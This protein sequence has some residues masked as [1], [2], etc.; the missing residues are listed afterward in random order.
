[1]STLHSDDTE[2]L[3]DPEDSWRRARITEEAIAE[4]RKH[5]GVKQPITSWTR[6]ANAEAL[7]HFAL[8]VGDDNP[9]WWDR[10]YASHSKVGRM[11]APPS[12]LYTVSTDVP[13]PRADFGTSDV[14]WLP[15]VMGLWAGDRWRWYDRIWVDET[16]T[17]T[18]ELHS[19]AEK[20][21]SFGGRGVVQ[22]ELLTFEGEGPR[23]LAEV[24]R[25][26]FRVERESTRSS[27]KNLTIPRARYTPE[28]RQAIIDQYAREAS[29]RRG[30]EP[31]FWDDV[32]TGDNMPPLVK[33]PLT[34]TGMIGWLLGWGSPGTPTNRMLYDWLGRHPAGRLHNPETGIDDTMEGAHWDE[35]L[36][37]ESGMARGF[38][39]GAQRIAG[40]IH[41]L[42]DWC[43]DE[44]EVLDLDARLKAPNFLGD[45][46]W[47]NGKVTGKRLEDRRGVVSCAITANNQRDEISL[48]ATARVALPIRSL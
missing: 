19:V 11:F 14:E 22:T 5:I 27:G 15:G 45:T 24:Y 29:Q 39:F 25:T 17:A 42:T 18:R 2:Q 13:N 33:G 9:L 48:T 21:M 10:S 41:L 16:I 43:G 3:V 35:Y 12:F 44:G 7:W 20:E 32:N 30:A 38:D 37:R 28:Q 26:V 34:L 4:M 36:A 31:R 23:K 6:T 1:V 46:T 8:G 40:A 47:F